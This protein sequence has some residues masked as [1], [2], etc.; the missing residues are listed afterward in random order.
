MS[1]ESLRHANPYESNR[2][3]ERKKER[4]KERERENSNETASR[5]KEEWRM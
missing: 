4:K 3:P 5:Y 1:D 2:R